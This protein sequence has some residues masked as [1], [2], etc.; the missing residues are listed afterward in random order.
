MS[1]WSGSSPESSNAVVSAGTTSI[2]LSI[3]N[4]RIT[5]CPRVSA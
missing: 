4:A 2:G 5:G 1:V 3:A